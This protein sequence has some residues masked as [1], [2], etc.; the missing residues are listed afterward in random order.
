MLGGG[1]GLLLILADAGG[2]S[3]LLQYF[4]QLVYVVPLGLSTVKYTFQNKCLFLVV[5]LR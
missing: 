1:G 2:Q 3:S 4:D 5:G